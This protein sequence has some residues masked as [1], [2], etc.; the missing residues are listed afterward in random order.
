MYKKSS[1]EKRKINNFI[2][3]CCNARVGEIK[4]R[5]KGMSEGEIV[6][7][8][9]KLKYKITANENSSMNFSMLALCISTVSILMT[10]VQFLMNS[11]KII[12][13]EEKILELKTLFL[14]LVVCISIY[15]IGVM[16]YSVYLSVKNAK[17]T[18]ALSYIDDFG[19][20]E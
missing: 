17:A 5:I 20:K 11:D 12:L 6:W 16:C 8:R 10:I 19:K 9:A 18:M 3:F 1:Y 2:K 14:V 15:V 4:R 7:I 13:T